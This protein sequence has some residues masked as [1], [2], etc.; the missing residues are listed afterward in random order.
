[1]DEH[2]S[3][4]LNEFWPLM[5][6]ALKGSASQQTQGQV[7]SLQAQNLA[8]DADNHVDT[9]RARETEVV[10]TMR[11]FGGA[12]H[13]VCT[14]ASISQARS[15]SE[16]L[17]RG[18]ASN[19][20]QAMLRNGAGSTDGR[21][22]NGPADDRARRFGAMTST[23]CAANDYGGAGASIG[24]SAPAATHNLD[25]S[26][27]EMMFG[28]DVDGD[29]KA[30]GASDFFQGTID[31]P[32]EIA[33]W[34]AFKSNLG[35]QLPFDNID[36]DKLTPANAAA[37]RD[38]LSSQRQYLARRSVAASSFIAYEAIRQPA[39][40]AATEYLRGMYSEMGRDPNIIPNNPSAYQQQK[41]TYHDYYADVNTY[42]QQ[43]TKS[44]E[45]VQR[46]Q[47]LALATLNAQLWNI[48]EILRRID[49]N[50]ANNTLPALDVEYQKLQEGTSRVNNTR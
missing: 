27:T 22:F 1:M 42:I 5:E 3:W 40:D 38:L 14:P 34:D 45:N 8:I 32:E 12:E 18:A 10:Q 6:E 13:A 2:E 50:I 9:R 49:M 48:T 19:I 17:A 21:S 28:R 33:A 46:H 44:P 30:D 29:G 26:L 7:S 20:A 39:S 43:Y 35:L 15:A 37:Y 16:E 11:R 4:I 36:T 24:C 47:A 31:Q 25:I 23:Y 41:A